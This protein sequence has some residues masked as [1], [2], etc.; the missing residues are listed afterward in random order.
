M[1]RARFGQGKGRDPKPGLGVKKK[2]KRKSQM[3]QKV[4]RKGGGRE[5][6]L[7]A[8]LS[9]TTFLRWKG[10]KGKSAFATSPGKKPGGTSGKN[11]G[12]GGKSPHLW[13]RRGNRF[14]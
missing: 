1:R 10:K 7:G 12:G 5:D 9:I 13:E 6:V 8:A 11:E 14:R 2:K 4:E 3:S